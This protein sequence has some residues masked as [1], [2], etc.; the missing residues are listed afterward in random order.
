MRFQPSRSLGWVGG[1]VGAGEGARARCK[2]VGARELVVRPLC[3]TVAVGTMQQ[4]QSRSRIC[5]ATLSAATSLDRKA[6]QKLWGVGRHHSATAFCIRGR[7]LFFHFPFFW[8]RRDRQRSPRSH[9]VK[10]HTTL[11][12]ND[13]HDNSREAP[14][15]SLASLS[16]EKTKLEIHQS[17]GVWECSASPVATCRVHRCRADFVWLHSPCKHWLRFLCQRPCVTTGQ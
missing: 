5:I 11:H 17:V 9:G 6:Q 14:T 10:P 12:H 16:A 3:D 8:T 2:Q 13:A 4:Y 1:C 7:I 15:Q